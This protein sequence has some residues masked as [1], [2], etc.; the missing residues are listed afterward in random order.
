MMSSRS[1]PGMKMMEWTIIS[2]FS[3][4]SI[5]V[6]IKG[7]KTFNES[8]FALPVTYRYGTLWAFWLQMQRYRRWMCWGTCKT[9]YAK[10]GG[11]QISACNW[12]KAEESSWW[13]RRWGE[14]HTTWKEPMS[15]TLYV[16][17]TR[18]S[19]RRT[20]LVVGTG[21][22]IGTWSII[23]IHSYLRCNS[24]KVF[25]THQNSLVHLHTWTLRRHIVWYWIP[26]RNPCLKCV[27][28]EWHPR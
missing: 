22:R 12:W 10:E 14:N 20:P 28:L 26:H 3:I 27:L 24:F 8:K 16:P 23:I 6:Q 11:P 18:Q 13:N 19:I 1:V 7:T 9:A 2:D 4:L 15:T 5:L 17:C 21:P 25:R